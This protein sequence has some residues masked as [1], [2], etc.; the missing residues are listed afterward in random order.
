[1][2]L[3][4]QLIIFYMSEH[5]HPVDDP[6][7]QPPSQDL[8]DPPADLDNAS[9][10]PSPP[11]EDPSPNSNLNSNRDEVD[12]TAQKQQEELPASSELPAQ[13]SAEQV[14]P[15]E[16]IVD[17][18]IGDIG[19]VVEIANIED[20]PE[21]EYLELVRDMENKKR[22]DEA[23]QIEGREN[24]DYNVPKTRKKVEKPK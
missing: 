6:E 7:Q 18:D 8:P 11:D 5:D 22:E 12:S 3:K 19:E 2:W 17:Q 4:V 1:M 14:P 23:N 16:P 20:I 10:K 9:D 24:F 15:Q 21:D 13:D